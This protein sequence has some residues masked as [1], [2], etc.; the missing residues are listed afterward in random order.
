M[1]SMSI[2]FVQ[3]DNIL[4]QKQMQ[5]QMW[6]ASEQNGKS[7]NVYLGPN[8]GVRD[9]WQDGHIYDIKYNKT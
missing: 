6:T 9:W 2:W 1:F 4:R 7:L 5:K 8:S 3:M